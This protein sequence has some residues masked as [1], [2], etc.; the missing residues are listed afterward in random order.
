[1]PVFQS[2]NEK[3]CLGNCVENYYLDLMRE[4]DSFNSEGG[5]AI[6][7]YKHY[8]GQFNL[9]NVNSSETVFFFVLFVRIIFL[10]TVLKKVMLK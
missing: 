8:N 10:G 4:R 2:N 9:R 1:M 3:K 6:I 5:T 7:G